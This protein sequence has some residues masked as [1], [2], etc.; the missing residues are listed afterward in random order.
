[1]CVCVQADRFLTRGSLEEAAVSLPM[2]SKAP[3]ADDGDGEDI[4]GQ[5]QKTAQSSAEGNMEEVYTGASVCVC[6][7][8]FV[9]V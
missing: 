9:F 7:C 6:V 8:V 2:V 4:Y 3:E 5:L 1:V